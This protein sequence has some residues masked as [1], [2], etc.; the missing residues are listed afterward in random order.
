LSAVAQRAKAE[1]KKQSIFSLRGF[2]DCSAALAMTVSN[3][4]FVGLNF[5]SGP[6][7]EGNCLN[8]PLRS[9]VIMLLDRQK[10]SDRRHEENSKIDRKADAPQDRAQHGP[11]AEVGEDIG[12]SHA[13]NLGLITGASVMSA[14]FAAASATIDIATARPE[15]V[16]AGM[17]ITFAIA[18]ILIVV[19]LATAANNAM[20]AI[21]RSVVFNGIGTMRTSNC[22]IEISAVERKADVHVSVLIFRL[23]GAKLAKIGY[24]RL[25]RSR[26]PDRDAAERDVDMFSSQKDGRMSRI[27]T[28]GAAQLGPIQ[29]GGDRA[30]AVRS[31]LDLMRQARQRVILRD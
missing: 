28:I 9:D 21:H 2:M 1:A 6:Q 14:V 20:A 17:R 26:L 30:R 10:A 16:A 5:Q 15:A 27:V 11:I 23:G 8:A 4:L 24:R 3:A 18:A 29:R 7:D 19:A 13:R 12:N 25:V 22:R 31:M